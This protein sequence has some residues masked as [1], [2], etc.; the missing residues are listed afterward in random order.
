M[1]ASGDRGERLHHACEGASAD[2]YGWENLFSPHRD[3]L[4]PVVGV[5]WVERS[6]AALSPLVDGAGRRRKPW[7]EA[8]WGCRG[9]SSNR[10]R[11]QG[12]ASFEM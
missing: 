5:D 2:L 1:S 9:R 6:I 4:A 12:G 8:P 7:A 3:A 11:Q 10:R